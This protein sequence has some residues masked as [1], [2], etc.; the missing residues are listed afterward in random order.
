[1]F[2]NVF[3]V[4]AGV[5]IGSGIM[6]TLGKLDMISYNNFSDMMC[7][8]FFAFSDIIQGCVHTFNHD[9]GLMDIAGISSKLFNQHKDII[10]F[11]F[12]K[13]GQLQLILGLYKLY[14]VLF[15]HQQTTQ[16]I[17]FTIFNEMFGVIEEYIIHPKDN[18]YFKKIAPNAPIHGRSVLVGIALIIWKLLR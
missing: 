17:Y 1:M 16:I 9:R 6:F 3:R 12:P 8:S 14:V 2:S 18:Q 4:R 11:T 10:R 5:I 13:W 15:K 7:L